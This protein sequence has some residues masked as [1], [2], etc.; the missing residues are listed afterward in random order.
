MIFISHTERDEASAKAL[1]AFLSECIEIPPERIRRTGA[2]A[3]EDY[4]TMCK[5]LKEEISSSDVILAVVS[6]ESLCGNGVVFEL[7]AAWAMDKLL[8]LFFLSGIDFRDMPEPLSNYP[9]VEADHPHAH[10]TIMDMAR[11]IADFLGLPER[12][13]G[14]TFISLERLLDTMQNGPAAVREVRQAAAPP[15]PGA[16]IR[17]DAVRNVPEPNDRDF[18]DIVCS[19]EV[20]TKGIARPQQ[21]VIRALWDDLFKSFASHLEAPQNEDYIRKLFLEF[22]KEK[23]TTFADNCR[24]CIYK[25]PAVTFD[26][27]WQIIRRF[28]GLGYIASAR[29]P[30]SPFRGQASLSH[31][32]MTEKGEDY[33]RRT[34]VVRKALQEWVCKDKHVQRSAMRK[35][36]PPPRYE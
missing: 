25:K 26:S 18:C 20:V 16:P 17:L 30:H 5:R 6:P 32:V 35:L 9:S 24:L 8:F 14:N 27:Y 22:C 28:S 4:A 12:K 11:D 7:G 23:D 3:H 2:S 1:A 31:W 10:I 21:V 19:Y 29:A 36:S 13:N 15:K 34:L 33:L